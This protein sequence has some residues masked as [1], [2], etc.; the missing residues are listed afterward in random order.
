MYRD[1]SA[2]QPPVRSLKRCYWNIHGWNSKTI[3]NKLIDPEF[4]QTISKSDI[5]G[6]SEIHSDIEVS[7]PGFMSLK[8]KI[9]EKRHKGPK[10]SGG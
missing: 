4:L 3:G 6:L 2:P 9:R 7:L 5:V 1:I 8:Q 10:I